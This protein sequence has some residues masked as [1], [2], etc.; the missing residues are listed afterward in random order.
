MFALVLIFCLVFAVIV[1]LFCLF[2][3]SYLV[4]CLPLLL[5]SGWPVLVFVVARV[6]V[7]CLILIIPYPV[8]SFLALGSLQSREFML[9]LQRCVDDHPEHLLVQVPGEGL[10]LSWRIEV[11][12][13]LGLFFLSLFTVV[14]SLGRFYA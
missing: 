14:K 8:S 1:V 7:V 11:L 2:C 10:F 6:S 3:L 9:R 13:N 12:W 5:S 4:F